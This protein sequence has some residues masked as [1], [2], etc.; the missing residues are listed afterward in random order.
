MSKAIWELPAERTKAGRPHRVPLTPLALDLIGE[1]NGGEYVFS[2]GGG[3]PFAGVSIGQAMR[4]EREALGL[5]SRATVHDLRRTTATHLGDLGIDR[6][7]IG[8]L[9]NHAE[10][11]V[12]GKVYDLSAYAEPKRLAMAAWSAKLTEIIT[13]KAAPSNVTPI[14]GAATS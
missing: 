2:N 7:I 5:A 3:K 14:K 1:P 11:G 6:L 4:R 12:T 9:L 8:K 13:G 10:A